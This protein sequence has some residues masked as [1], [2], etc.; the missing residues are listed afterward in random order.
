MADTP[1][2]ITDSQGAKDLVLYTQGIIDRQATPGINVSFLCGHVYT[3]ANAE[4]I[5]SDLY[6]ISPAP[7]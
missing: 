6:V 4:T 5:K 1:L 3:Y 7:R 2:K